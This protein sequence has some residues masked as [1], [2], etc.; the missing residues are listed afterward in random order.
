MKQILKLAL[1]LLTA[2]GVFMYALTTTPVNAVAGTI[3]FSP[4][5]A[6][7]NPGS[8]FTIEVRGKVPSSGFAGGATVNVTYPTNLLQATT[9][10]VSGGVLGGSNPTINNGTVTYGVFTIPSRAVNDQK[11]FT[12]TFK[13]LAAGTAT[14]NFTANTNINDGPT[15]KQPATITIV[16]PTCPAGQVGTPPTCS[17]PPPAPTPTPTVTPPAS[18]PGATSAPAPTPTPTVTTPNTSPPEQP[19]QTLEP[20]QPS[21]ALDFENTEVRAS[22]DSAVVSWATNSEAT[23]TLNYGT[24]PSKLDNT[25]TVNTDET[26][27]KFTAT[28]SKLQLATTYHYS[29]VAQNTA[30][31]IVSKKGSF[32]TKAY[33]VLLRVLQ[34]NQP[35]NGAGL[36]IQNFDNAYTTT[37]KGEV[38][39][40]LKPGDYTAKITKES[41]SEEQKFTIKALAFTAGKTPDTQVIEVKLAT[42]ISAPSG[43]NPMPY[44]IAAL[45]ALTLLGSVIALIAWKRH[46]DS[47]ATLGYQSVLD[48]DTT[49][50]PEYSNYVAA[51]ATQEAAYQQPYPTAPQYDNSQPEALY[52]TPTTVP[53]YSAPVYPQTTSTML[54]AESVPMNA[55]AT[56]ED[57]PADMWSAPIAQTIP[58]QSTLAYTRDA[59][60]PAS[61][62]EQSNTIYHP[63][64]ASNDSDPY[65]PAQQLEEPIITS[66]TEA[67]PVAD[68]KNKQDFE[69]NDDNSLTIRHNV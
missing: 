49:P 55:G 4:S 65:S 41:L 13:A 19:A 3:Y 31:E 34:N 28:L 58:A 62:A 64:V 68:T 53:T 11:L 60:S 27:S 29:I 66:T 42:P 17:T 23:A 10:S 59:P 35:L 54:P 56:T 69:Y 39:L 20:T 45:F 44:V 2:L 52:Q 30:G 25:A 7:F 33:P 67:Q 5:A 6:T 47:Q 51:E 57:E 8:T 1:P 9:T 24:I 22:F 61:A 15:A 21:E 40:A 37:A 48:F 16:N 18:K 50:P 32:T 12:I 38:S 36:K 43:N 46:R 63:G 26:K 14:L